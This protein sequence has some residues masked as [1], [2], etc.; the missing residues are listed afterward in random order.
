MLQINETLREQLLK[1]LNNLAEYNN[2]WGT[3][4]EAD[5]IMKLKEKLTK[6][7]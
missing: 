3:E 4:K 6:S 7:T 5:R 1:A 2:G